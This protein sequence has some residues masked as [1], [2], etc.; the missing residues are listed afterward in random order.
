MKRVAAV[1]SLCVLP[2][3]S[4]AQDFEFKGVVVGA[5]VATA[6]IEQRLGIKC[7]TSGGDQSCSGQTTMMSL[8]AEVHVDLLAGSVA[9]MDVFYERFL[10]DAADK[11]LKEKYGQ[12][13]VRK[14]TMVVWRNTRGDLVILQRDG[15]LSFTSI[16]NQKKN[17][18][19]VRKMRKDF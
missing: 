1:M 7:A 2:I 17:E 11:A 12:P 19:D 15:L 13:Y 16:T 8:P 6:D 14:N 9:R 10:F 3:V 4:A 5:K 18:Q